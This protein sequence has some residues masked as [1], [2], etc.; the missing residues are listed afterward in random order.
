M[1][2]LIGRHYFY[3]HANQSVKRACFT[4]ST[5]SKRARVQKLNW[6]LTSEF[7]EAAPISELRPSARMAATIQSRTWRKS[8]L[9][10]RDH[11][12]GGLNPLD[13][14]FSQQQQS[15]T[16]HMHPANERCIH[17]W[18]Q[19]R[20]LNMRDGESGILLVP[21]IFNTK[22]YNNSILLTASVTA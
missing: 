9:T 12:V 5:C 7:Y 14:T 3:Y 22:L 13:G 1:D 4:C 20:L 6:R 16:H 21:R 19:P 8:K 17:L 10:R 2:F 11:G 15:T 18:M